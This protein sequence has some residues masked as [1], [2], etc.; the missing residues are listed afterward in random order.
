MPFSHP[1][2]LATATTE[3][4]D[5]LRNGE[6]AAGVTAPRAGGQPSRRL[7]AVRPTGTD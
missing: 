1:E 7:R 2:L 5:A 3:F 4:V 6:V